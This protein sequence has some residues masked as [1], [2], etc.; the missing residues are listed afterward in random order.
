MNSRVSVDS[1]NALY[2]TDIP[3]KIKFNGTEVPGKFRDLMLKTL[4]FETL[5]SY[6]DSNGVLRD[7]WGNP[8]YFRY[9]GFFNKTKYDIISAG[10]DG[11][12]GKTAFSSMKELFEEEK[13][14][15]KINKQF[16]DG[17]DW[18]CDDIANF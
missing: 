17:K 5:R 15:E 7:A 3:D 6:C 11:A 9:P 16:Y 13:T 12:F 10:P 8:I 4:D 1:I 18:I 14:K 2:T